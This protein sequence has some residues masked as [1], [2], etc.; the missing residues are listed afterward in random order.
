VLFG[1]EVH[2]WSIPNY[3]VGSSRAFQLSP[4]ADRH[5]LELS[6]A[7][8]ALDSELHPPSRELLRKR[9]VRH[10]MS[11]TPKESSFQRQ[12]I[13]EHDSRGR[14]V[15]LNWGWHAGGGSSLSWRVAALASATDA[16]M[17]K[18]RGQSGRL[19]PFA[20]WASSRLEHRSSLVDWPGIVKNR[21]RELVLDTVA[22]QPVRHSGVFD[23]DALEVMLKRHFDG[24]EDSH[25]T[26][27][28]VLE[29][30]LGISAR[31]QINR[32]VRT[33]PG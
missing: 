32:L 26:V 19:R 6:T 13:V 27:V 5:L 33:H 1:Q 30:A 9:D 14:A 22:S 18:I 12:F 24:S 25:Q 28:R 8:F 10:R 4:Y 23:A 21:L 15:P 3:V 2:F 31:S 20:Q 29:L 7:A 17:T 16:A 11:G